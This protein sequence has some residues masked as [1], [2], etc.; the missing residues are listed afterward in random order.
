MLL[1]EFCG[2][3]WEEDFKGVYHICAWRPSWSCDQH[4]I[5][6]EGRALSTFLPPPQPSEAKNESNC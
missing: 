4:H 2:N 6:K 1:T 3:Q 5:N